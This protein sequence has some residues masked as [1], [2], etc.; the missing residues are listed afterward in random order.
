MV[1][2]M[3][4]LWG[5]TEYMEAY[6]RGA[7]PSADEENRHALMTM[8][9]QSAS[10]GSAAALSRM[11]WEIDVRHVLSAVRVPSLVLNRSEESPFIVNG[12]PVP[13]R[14][15][16]GSEAGR[17]AR[18]RPRSVRRAARAHA[19]CNRGVPPGG[20]GR[21]QRSTPSP[22]VCSRRSSSRTSSGRP[23]G[24]SSSATRVGARSSKLTTLSFAGSSAVSGGASSTPRATGSSPRSTAR[25]VR[26]VRLRHHRGRP[27]A[28]SGDPRRPSCGRVRDR[29]RQG[30]RH[31]RPHRG[32][33]RIERRRGRGR[34]VEHREGSRRRLG[35]PVHGARGGRS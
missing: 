21:S 17:A 19:R 18:R 6:V 25:H 16:S 24:R 10:P 3:E 31:R 8:F 32:A 12:R 30:G 22:T 1:A 33:G 2:E 29:R 26:S 34:G 9:R 23:R 14:E 28:R 4:R 15:H 7:A 20:V 27:R 13:G 11:N 5:T 35:D